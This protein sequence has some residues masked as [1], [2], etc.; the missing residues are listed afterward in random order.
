MKIPGMVTHCKRSFNGFG[1]FIAFVVCSM[2]TSCVST[3]NL[4]YFRDIPDTMSAPVAVANITPFT[5]PKI[6]SNDILAITVQTVVQ[7]PGNMPITSTSQGTFSLVNGIMVDKNGYIELSLLGFIKVA[8]L[9]TAEAKEVIK[10]R[11]KDFYKDPVVNVR[12]ANF[13]IEVY[14]DVAKPG[15]VNI[16]NEKASILDVLALAGDVNITAKKGNVMLV[17]TEGDEKKFYRFDL[18]SS[19]VYQ[20]PAFWLRQHDQVFVEPN[21]YKAQSSDQTFLRNLG[22]VSTVIS[23]ASLVLIFRSVK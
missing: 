10:Q 7:S 2:A 18:T 6:E 19:K 23:I 11:A 3:K 12:I 5:D 15:V 21:K 16:P 17:R 4:L 13:D 14:G 22:I 8:G 20:H 9:T 1:L